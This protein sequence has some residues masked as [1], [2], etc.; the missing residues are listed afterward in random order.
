MAG[1]M[2]A[3]QMLSF[4]KRHS[5]QPPSLTH[6][7]ELRAS[8][9]TKRRLAN[10]MSFPARRTSGSPS[11][12]RLPELSSDDASSP[13]RGKY[14]RSRKRGSG[15]TKKP[16]RSGKGARSLEKLDEM[17]QRGHLSEDDH[18]TAARA[19][20]ETVSGS[21]EANP[22][23]P[24]ELLVEGAEAEE[25]EVVEEEL[26]FDAAE[27]AAEERDILTPMTPSRHMR[28][29]E[30]AEVPEENEGGSN[31]SNHMSLFGLYANMPLLDALAHGGEGYQRPNTAEIID[32]PD[33]LPPLTTRM[34]SVVGFHVSSP[35]PS[36]PKRALGRGVQ[37]WREAKE[38]VCPHDF[39]DDTAS[40]AASDAGEDAAAASRSETQM[41]TLVRERGRAAKQLARA[42][43]RGETF[44]KE[45]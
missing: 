16:R 6:A 38:I 17:K 5:I 24:T 44:H 34:S 35:K 14:G 45:A 8:I 13:K 2:L 9:G 10:E 27:V 31:Q 18:K 22:S 32:D 12:N 39:A 3:Q 25:E 1:T 41:E 26:E 40:E 42:P 33:D 43:S 19:V 15:S 4:E 30:P 20:Q 21:G 37:E 11:P 23:A 7:H 28:V 29:H 36:R